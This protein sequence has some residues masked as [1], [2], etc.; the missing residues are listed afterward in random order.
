[1]PWPAPMPWPTP[2]PSPTPPTLPGFEEWLKDANKG[3]DGLFSFFKSRGLSSAGDPN[4]PGCKKEWETARKNCADWITQSD[5]P[6]G[7]TAGYK[8]IEDCARGVVSE[9][10]GGNQYEREPEK[11]PKRYRLR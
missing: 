7:V 6:P 10:C 8:D 3:L 1:M 4:G 5:P 9:R 11:P 2:T